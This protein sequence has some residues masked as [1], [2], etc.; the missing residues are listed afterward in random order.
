[1][2]QAG[3]SDGSHRSSLTDD[4]QFELSAS[5]STTTAA[6]TTAL[7]ASATAAG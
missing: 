3:G 4:Y 1:M 6:T 7:A 2:L 5:S